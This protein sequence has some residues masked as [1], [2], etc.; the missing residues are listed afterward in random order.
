MG[1]MQQ[2]RGEEFFRPEWSRAREKGEV[3]ELGQRSLDV[4]S[5]LLLIRPSMV[6]RFLSSCQGMACHGDT[7]PVMGCHGSTVRAVVVHQL[8]G[9]LWAIGACRDYRTGTRHP[10][11]GSWRQYTERVA[12]LCGLLALLVAAALPRPSVVG[13]GV[14]GSG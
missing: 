14:L 13:S 5:L 7:V 11:E 9:E 10:R 1:A 12:V 4:L 3:G 2:L 8:S 6:V